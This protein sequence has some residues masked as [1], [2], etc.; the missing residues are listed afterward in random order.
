MNLQLNMSFDK[1][2]KKNIEQTKKKIKQSVN[3]NNFISQCINNIDEINRLINTSVK[4]LREW[5]GLY[6]PEF[7]RQIRDNE[8]FIELILSKIRALNIYSRH[9]PVTV[10]IG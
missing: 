10:N 8:K 1:Y 2:F 9:S 4:R 5:Y 3:F 7:S 6:N